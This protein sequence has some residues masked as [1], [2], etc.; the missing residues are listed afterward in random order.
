[1]PDTA[2]ALGV[3]RAVVHGVFLVAAL[4]TSFSDLGRIFSRSGP[5]SGPPDAPPVAGVPAG[6]AVSGQTPSTTTTRR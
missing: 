3:V 5:A 1:M 2:L 4:A 6:A